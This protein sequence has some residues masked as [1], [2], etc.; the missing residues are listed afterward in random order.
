MCSPSKRLRHALDACGVT[1]QRA[2]TWRSTCRT[3]GLSTHEHMCPEAE[4]VGEGPDVLESL[5]PRG[6]AGFDSDT[7]FRRGA[8]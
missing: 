3:S 8:G 5:F 1:W 6:Y 4:W 2:V 7:P